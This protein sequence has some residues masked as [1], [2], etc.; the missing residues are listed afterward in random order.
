[1]YYDYDDYVADNYDAIMAEDCHVQE[2]KD[3]LNYFEQLLVD[4]DTTNFTLD[5]IKA[6]IKRIKKILGE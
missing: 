1:M 6:S 5:E 4:N 2:I 3:E